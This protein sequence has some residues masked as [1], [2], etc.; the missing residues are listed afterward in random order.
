MNKILKY[1]EFK[2]PYEAIGKRNL[3]SLGESIKKTIDASPKM[4]EFEVRTVGKEHV[5]IKGRIC[6]FRDFDPTEGFVRI[7]FPEGEYIMSPRDY[8]DLFLKIEFLI[9][10]E[11]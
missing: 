8:L 5:K 7:K 2:K 1:D 11:S 10:V 3:K 6:P 4:I 9:Q